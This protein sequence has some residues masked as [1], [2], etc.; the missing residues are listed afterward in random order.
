MKFTKQG[1]KELLDNKANLIIND[2]LSIEELKFLAQQAQE[3][4]RQLTIRSHG[5]DLEDF[6]KVASAGG[7]YV[8]IQV[9]Y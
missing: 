4:K 5:K 7:G 2:D 9:D 6:K 1:L 3:N 8:T